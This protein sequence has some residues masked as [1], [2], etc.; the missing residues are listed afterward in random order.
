MKFAKKFNSFKE[1][2]KELAKVSFSAEQALCWQTGKL[3]STEEEAV[4]NLAVNVAFDRTTGNGVGW[5][6]CKIKISAYGTEYTTGGGLT[7][8]WE[9]V[10]GASQMDTFDGEYVFFV[11][12]P[13]GKAPE[14]STLRKSATEH[15]WAE[16]SD[17][18]IGLE[19]ATKF[20]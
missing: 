10:L 2:I 17:V 14:D 11:E 8:G 15:G 1:G 18:M 3:P 9:V 5:D 19:G 16:K 20:I 12:H 6:A 13:N 4:K 7:F